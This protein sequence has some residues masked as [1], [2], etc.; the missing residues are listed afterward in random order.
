[1]TKFWTILI[2]KAFTLDK[3]N[4]NEKLKLVSEKGRKNGG[5][6]RKC[7]LHQNFLFPQCF[8]NTFSTGSKSHIWMVKCLQHKL[9]RF[10]RFT[11]CLISN[12][13]YQNYITNRL[14]VIAL[15]RTKCKISNLSGRG[16]IKS[17]IKFTMHALTQQAD[18]A[19][20]KSLFKV[21]FDEEEY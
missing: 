18:M 10:A 20:N 16:L 12:S 5:T 11:I 7:W 6:W 4:L 1:M 17:A 2:L 8:Q 14:T 15:A 19:G 21:L 3:M 13:F 9:C